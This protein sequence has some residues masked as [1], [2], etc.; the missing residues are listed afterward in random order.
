MFLCKKKNP[1]S[2]RLSRSLHFSLSTRLSNML[3]SFSDAPQSNWHR[4]SW[5]YQYSCVKSK[6]FFTTERSLIFKMLKMLKKKVASCIDHRTHLRG[7]FGP[8]SDMRAVLAGIGQNVPQTS[9]MNAL[10]AGRRLLDVLA[11]SLAVSF[12]RH[13]PER[14][15]RSL[16]LRWH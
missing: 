7:K 5:V 8:L 9:D 2:L 11:Q 3:L 13:A 12:Q 10:P 14:D 15:E 6:I 1:L 4:L 16:F